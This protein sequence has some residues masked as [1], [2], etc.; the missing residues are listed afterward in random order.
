MDCYFNLAIYVGFLFSTGIW[1][2]LFA[3]AFGTFIKNRD[4]ILWMA[5]RQLWGGSY[6]VWDSKG[7]TNVFIYILVSQ[8]SWFPFHCCKYFFS[9]FRAFCSAFLWAHS[10]YLRLLD[11]GR[12]YRAVQCS[13]MSSAARSPRPE[14]LEPLQTSSACYF[15]TTSYFCVGIRW[16]SPAVP[17]GIWFRSLN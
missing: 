14:G 13:E 12:V 11:P 10:L 6:K 3:E 15:I 2:Y 9:H 4:H 1:C 17:E 7:G 8:S 5:A 16:H